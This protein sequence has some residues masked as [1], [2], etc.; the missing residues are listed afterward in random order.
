VDESKWVTV[1]LGLLFIV[2]LIS[3]T[4]KRKTQLDSQKKYVLALLNL[5]FAINIGL[6]DYEHP[7]SKNKN[8]LF[9][10]LS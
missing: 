7:K 9:I 5:Y 2:V 8:G 10:F 6:I 1:S 4:K 3:H